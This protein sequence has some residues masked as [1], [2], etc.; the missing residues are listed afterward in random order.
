MASTHD[1]AGDFMSPPV[2]SSASFFVRWAGVFAGPCRSSTADQKR[3]RCTGPCGT[4]D[5]GSVKAPSSYVA[6]LS[7]RQEKGAAIKPRLWVTQRKVKSRKASRRLS[8]SP[9]AKFAAY[10]W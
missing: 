8:Y 7:R 4:E 10:P 2:A 1:Q 9:T 6:D 3:W 5:H